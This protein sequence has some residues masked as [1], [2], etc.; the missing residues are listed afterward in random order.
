[1]HVRTTLATGAAA[2]LAISLT[3]PA[4]AEDDH[5]FIGNWTGTWDNGQV[6]E[7]RV[8]SI[9]DDGRATA[10]Y[11]AA[12]GDGRFYFDIT[13]DGIETTLKRSG[14]VLEFRRPKMRYR[15]TLTG[16]DTPGFPLHQSREARHPENGS[17]AAIGMCRADQPTERELIPYHGDG[18]P[19]PTPVDAPAHHTTWLAPR[20]ARASIRTHGVRIAARRPFRTGRTRKPGTGKPL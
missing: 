11:C 13:P 19:T 12:R 1:M 10:L 9:D 6:N 14:A 20:P 2:A 5:P 18:R 4:A 8:V 3:N 17:S 7:F 15:F 16:D